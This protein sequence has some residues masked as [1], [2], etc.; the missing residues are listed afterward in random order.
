MVGFLLCKIRGNNDNSEGWRIKYY[1]VLGTSTFKK[2]L[3]SRG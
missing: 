2:S 3:G 1:K